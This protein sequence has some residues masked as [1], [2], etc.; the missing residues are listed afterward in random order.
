MGKPIAVIDTNVIILVL[1]SRTKETKDVRT[2]REMVE[3]NLDTLVERRARFVI[4]SPVVAE[5]CRDDK[6]IEIARRFARFAPRLRIEALDVE[7]AGVAGEMS[8]AALQARPPDRTR[9]AVKYD[10]LIAGAA[11]ALDASWLCTTNVRDMRRCLDAIDSKVE[12]VSMDLAP[13][14]KTLTLPHV[15]K[16]PTK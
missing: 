6:G 3:A 10:A 15:S 7:A 16:A 2:R 11:H 14:G 12:I 13:F 1:S 8:R 4:P 9:D 5:L